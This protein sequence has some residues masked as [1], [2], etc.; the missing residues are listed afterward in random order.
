MPRVRNVLILALLLL[1]GLPGARAQEEDSVTVWT[2][3]REIDG[4]LDI[5][6]GQ[7]LIVRGTQIA[8]DR[9]FHVFPGALLVVESVPGQLTGFAAR[10]QTAGWEGHVEG[11]AYLN[12]TAQDPVVLD[13]V[14][15]AAQATGDT[16]F[17]STGVVV[18]EGL[19]ETNHAVFMNYTSGVK[20]GAN[21]TVRLH[22]TTF[23]SARGLGLVASQGEIWANDTT[24]RGRGAGLWSVA[25]GKSNLRDVTFENGGIAIM[26]NGN[27]TNVDGMRVVGSDG[28]VRTTVG[29]FDGSDIECIGYTQGGVIISKP[30]KGTRLPTARIQGLRVTTDA[31]N[32]SPAVQVL[33]APGAVLRDLDIGPVTSQGIFI[34][35]RMPEISNVTF[36]GTAHF[37]VVAMD[38]EEDAPTAQIGQ[39]TPGEAGWLFVASRFTARVVDTKGELAEGVTV[40]LQDRNGSMALRRTTGAGGTTASGVVVVRTVDA[41]GKLE[42]HLYDVEARSRDGQESWTREGYQPDGEVLLV[43]LLSTPTEEVPGAGLPLVLLALLGVALASR[44]RRGRI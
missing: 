38:V 34:D 3:P 32:A 9:G 11:V 12:G 37:A 30:V 17:F 14:G 40:S 20:S 44:Y 33:N 21:A 13:R 23:D 31:V 25:D 4:W 35:R 16:I 8:L 15:G 27:Y 19:L 29:R 1:A 6:P 5:L 22:N 41:E 18:A 7:T 43:N 42:E 2:E 26:S 10:N 36:R 39:G 24:F 28:C